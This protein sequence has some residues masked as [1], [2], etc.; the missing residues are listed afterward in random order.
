MDDLKKVL[1]ENERLKS[2]LKKYENRKRKKWRVRRWTLE[3]VTSVILGGG[4]K[5]SIEQSITEVT[6][7]KKLSKDSIAD[8]IAHIF[9]RLTR[10]GIIG[11]II[12]IT[13]LVIL[14]IQ[15]KLLQKQNTKIDLQNSL[16]EQQGIRLDQQT[17][18][19]EADRRGSLVFLFS[20]IMDQV[21]KELTD[22]SSRELSPQLR[23]RIIALSSRL[24]PYHYLEGDELIRY[25][26]SPE[27]GQ[28]LVTLL[29]SKLDNSTYEEIF[30]RGDFSYADLK[31]AVLDS[32]IIN[33]IKLDHADFTNANLVGTKIVNSNLMRTNFENCYMEGADLSHSNL[34]YSRL[35][36]NLR[37]A[38]L[39]NTTFSNMERLSCTFNSAVIT[40]SSFE[41]S[42]LKGSDFSS[43]EIKDT[44]FTSADLDGVYIDSDSTWFNSLSDSNDINPPELLNSQYRFEK[45]V[46]ESIGMW[47][48]KYVIRNRF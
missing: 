19:Q 36:G 20:N 16:I 32:F 24:K 38:T 40:S 2:R 21:D 44:Y 25:P 29:E 30:R 33:G 10:I 46:D 26:L 1:K 12:A 31:G 9:W 42:K 4:L 11:L 27:R 47:L 14:V 18:L 23:G 34:N 39:E 6:E 43:A 35:S 48:G 17:Y 22:G 45:Y 5:S 15:T 13:P 7:E 8:L 37:K 28:L 3:R 41:G